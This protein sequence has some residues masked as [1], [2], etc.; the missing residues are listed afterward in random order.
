MSGSMGLP[1]DRSW[2]APT[3]HYHAIVEKCLEF[4]SREGLQQALRQALPPY[5]RHLDV[6]DLNAEEQTEFESS[7]RRVL[8]YFRGRYEQANDEKKRYFYGGAVMLSH[9]VLARM[10]EGYS[11]DHLDASRELRE[12]IVSGDVAEE[13]ADLVST[14]NSCSTDAR[15]ETGQFDVTRM[16]IRRNNEAEFEA[17]YLETGVTFDSVTGLMALK[18][19]T[20]S[21]SFLE[22]LRGEWRIETGSDQQFRFNA[23]G[24]IATDVPID[25]AVFCLLLGPGVEV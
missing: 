22:L 10:N 13:M 23:G 14:V 6:P 5:L 4:A 18:I 16:V 11:S 19:L 15:A 20:S 9:E 8:D 2:V 12:R 21:S 7:M 25:K 1:F 24:A 17:A 3:T